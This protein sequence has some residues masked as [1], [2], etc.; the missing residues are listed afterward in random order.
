[1]MPDSIEKQFITAFSD[2]WGEL[3]SQ[4]LGRDSALGLL[5]LREVSGEGVEA[6]L[7]VAATWSWGFFTECS[8]VIPGV[9]VCL[10][11]SEDGGQLEK[12]VK[13]ATDGLP[14]P[15]SRALLKA[16]F[17][18]AAQRLAAQGS[19]LNCGEVV[20]LELSGQEK[21]LATVVGNKAWV[22]T[23]ALSIGDDSDTQALMLYAP[24]GSMKV[25]SATGP[26]AEQAAAAASASNNPAAPAPTPSRRTPRREE[27]TVRN[28]ERLL[29][30]E[31]EVVVRFGTTNLPLREVVRLGPGMMIEL[32]RAVDEPVELLVNGRSMARGE[33]VVIDGYYG[34]R[35]T[36]IGVPSERPL[37]LIPGVPL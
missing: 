29:G 9:A 21:R 32:N 8:G 15:G 3:A 5:A 16:V 20:H 27:P 7:A 6:A 11:K 4:L 22:G 26:A 31:L 14:K 37:S 2:S 25:L 23:F 24:N 10:F 17:A 36:E 12:L 19:A 28:I 33:V 18:G 30:M 1:M 34:V 13:Q 35:I